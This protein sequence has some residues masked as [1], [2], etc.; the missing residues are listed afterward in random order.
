MAVLLI[1][2]LMVF[3]WSLYHLVFLR[4]PMVAAGS[5]FQV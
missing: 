2:G 5:L 4:T 3:L 1:S